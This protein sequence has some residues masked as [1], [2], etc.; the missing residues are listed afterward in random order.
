[1]EQITN[2]KALFDATQKDPPEAQPVF[3]LKSD[4][5]R[6]WLRLNETTIPSQAPVFQQSTPQTKA[7]F[8]LL[9]SRVLRQMRQDGIRRLGLA[10]PTVGCGT[11]TVAT[12][13]ALSLSRQIDLKVL[14]FDFN[15]RRP[16]LAKRFGLEAVAPHHCALSGLRRDF[17]STCLRV[18]HNLG[19]SLATRPNDA[20][21]E[22]LATTRSRALIEQIEREFEPD[23]MLFDLPPVLPHDDLVAAADLID[24]ALLV[25]RADH[26][27]IDQID[28]AERL[29]SE[30]K[31]CLGVVMNACR[32]PSQKELGN[33][34]KPDQ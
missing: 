5:A 21:A 17:D 26:S 15:L 3:S 13:L 33:A 12:S 25:G 2:P 8:D 22:L 16:A 27:T 23:I 1:M 29:V 4:P 14:L 32:F 6:A 24:A 31:P 18:N 11:T 10:S 19:L 28:R 20:P 7:A 34:R 9:R 30:Q